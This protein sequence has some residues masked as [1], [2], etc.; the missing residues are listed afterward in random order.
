MADG[1]DTD[2][3]LS[4]PFP[5]FFFLFGRDKSVGRSLSEINEISGH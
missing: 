3:L 1:A 2:S 4:P 5:F